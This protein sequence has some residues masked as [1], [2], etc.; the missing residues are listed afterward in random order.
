[1]LQNIINY[2]IKTWIFKV[3]F[4]QIIIISQYEKYPKIKCKNVEARKHNARAKK[5][6]NLG[7]FSNG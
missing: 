1:M 7:K 4:E 6:C 2:L 5:N 3:G